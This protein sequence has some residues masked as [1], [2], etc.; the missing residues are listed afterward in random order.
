MTAAISCL[1]RIASVFGVREK[2]MKFGVYVPCLVVACVA[3]LA[4]GELFSSMAH[5]ETALYA[6]RDIAVAIKDYIHEE[7]KRLDKLR[8]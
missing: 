4:C 7:E 2:V 1:V 8:K 5:L 3:T 6:E